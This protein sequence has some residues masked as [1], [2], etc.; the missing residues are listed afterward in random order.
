MRDVWGSA[1]V[2]VVIGLA[3]LGLATL[4]VLREPLVGEGRR[5]PPAAP[6]VPWLGSALAVALA[7]RGSFAGAGMLFLATLAYTVRVRWRL[8]HR[9]VRRTRRSAPRTPHGRG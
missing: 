5:P 6:L 1:A 9:S 2:L 4:L 7:V 8:R 3:T